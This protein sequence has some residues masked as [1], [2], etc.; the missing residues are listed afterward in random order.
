MNIVI[1][2]IEIN[3][4]LVIPK[5][6]VDDCIYRLNG[7]YIKLYLYLVNSYTDGNFDKNKV[8]SDLQLLQSDLE[9]GL[10]KLQELGLI[11]LNSQESL[12]NNGAFNNSYEDVKLNDLKD[13]IISTDISDYDGDDDFKEILQTVEF[14]I[15]NILNQN[16]IIKLIQI[17]NI[18]EK[19]KERV[20][21]FIE[22]C[23]D[24]SIYNF[25]Y[26]I[27][28]AKTMV[29][30]EEDDVD[31]LIASHDVVIKIARAL[32]KKNSSK[33]TADYKVISSWLRSYPFD[34]NVILLACDRTRLNAGCD[35][36]EYTKKILDEWEKKGIRNVE[37]IE[38]LDIKP[39][40]KHNGV[41]KKVVNNKFNNFEQRKDDL[42][43]DMNKLLQNIIK[44]SNNG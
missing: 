21:D 23:I 6:F 2:D 11:E 18:F 30:N 19:D 13:E 15:K 36:L 5:Y 10:N 14:L 42:N 35:S 28:T 37:D 22:K 4:C 3:K 29:E 39:V 34:E 25:N 12:I 20:L 38:V 33:D 9:N 32:G 40:I 16:D 31:N 26:M 43:S 7:E 1:R 44:D 8:A 17:Y 24:K 41:N 27:K